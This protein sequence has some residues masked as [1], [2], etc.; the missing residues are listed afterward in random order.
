MYAVTT[1]IVDADTVIA[2][3]APQD[4]NPHFHLSF[5]TVADGPAV[6]LAFRSV[7]DLVRLQAA[8][9]EVLPAGW[10]ASG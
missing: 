1:A 5:G 6:T 8:L 4:A 2:L 3:G 9:A 7:E 10:S